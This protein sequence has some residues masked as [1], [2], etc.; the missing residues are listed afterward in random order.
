MCH[1]GF[2]IDAPS[3]A[4]ALPPAVPGGS[5]SRCPKQSPFQRRNPS[6]VVSAPPFKLRA[7]CSDPRPMS[8]SCGSSCRAAPS[9]EPSAEVPPGERPN[10]FH[11]A[12]PE[13][14]QA[15]RADVHLGLLRRGRHRR[16]PRDGAPPGAAGPW[17]THCREPLPPRSIGE[18]DR[19]V[20]FHISTVA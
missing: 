7:S 9:T 3:V 8:T 14:H 12:R 4:S 5:G 2:C 6:I 16:S 19:K 10:S 15:A 13:V 17:Y 18:L 1:S 11:D 20:R